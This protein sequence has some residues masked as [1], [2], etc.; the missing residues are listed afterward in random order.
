MER[1]GGSSASQRADPRRPNGET[2][3]RS[4]DGFR[5]GEPGRRRE[6]DR[7]G[8]GR[9]GQEGSAGQPQAGAYPEAVAAE[10]T[11]SEQSAAADGADASGQSREAESSSEPQ[12][13]TSLP[14]ERP[15]SAIGEQASS[16]L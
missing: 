14:G 6:E 7:H 5:N 16:G 9:Y 11:A 10:R 1:I 3:R 12:G 13:Q 15:R 8:E 2:D 4:P